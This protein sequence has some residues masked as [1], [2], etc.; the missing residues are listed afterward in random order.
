L[1][2]D[3]T[4]ARPRIWSPEEPNLYSA[5]AVVGSDDQFTR[6]GIRE[7]G[8]RGNQILLNGQRVKLRG[9]N[10]HDDHPEWGSAAPAYLIRQDVEIMKRLGANAARMHYPPVEMFLD[11]CDQNGL[12]FLE[13]VP[14][15]QYRAE[16]LAKPAIQEKI[17]RHFREMLERD[18]GHVA[19]LTWSLGN[20]WP[21][22][23][24]SYDVIKSLV[25]YARSL[26]RSHP[27]TF[28]TGG[29]HVWRVHELVDVIS[30]NWAK[31]QWY[32]PVTYLDPEEGKKS[33][34]DLERIRARYPEKPVIVT[35]F[36]GAES[37]AGWHNWGNVKWSE[38]FQ[39]RNVEDSGR[40]ALAEDWLSGGCVWQ[41]SDTRTAPDR[42]LAGRLHGWNGK[43][44][45]D[46][47]RSPKLAYYRLQELVRK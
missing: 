46:A 45:V 24:K 11:Y 39:A 20:E 41:F 44:I 30:V 22:P 40:Y 18:A 47:Q 3:L 8:L 13:E 26:D 1:E 33:I 6:F 2:F 15:W 16:Q 43:G 10:R 32:D 21:D 31:Y 25:A 36:G 23:D 7:I 12:L 4:I 29:S 5:R 17:K 35:E 34:A 37:Q 28:V 9:V 42:F 38:E 27:I 19:V 14:S